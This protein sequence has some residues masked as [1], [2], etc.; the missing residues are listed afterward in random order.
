MNNDIRCADE[1]MIEEIT[2][3]VEELGGFVKYVQ[4]Q[5]GQGSGLQLYVSPELV[6]Q[7]NILVNDIR[8]KYDHRQ[9]KIKNNDPF[10]GVKQFLD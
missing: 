6:E 3:C 9:R 5:L 7:A 10:A 8:L 4:G 1:E 2:E